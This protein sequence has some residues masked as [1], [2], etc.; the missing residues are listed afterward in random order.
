MVSVYAYIR[1]YD[2]VGS[3]I[4]QKNSDFGKKL[5]EQSD[6]TGNFSFEK[7]MKDSNRI[8]VLLVG[9]EHSRTDTIMIASYDRDDKI[10]NI[11][12]IPRDTYYYREGRTGGSLKINAIYGQEG[13]E[14]L[15]S[16]V[17]EIAGIPIHKHVLIGYEG[18]VKGVDAL[19][20][21]EV[22]IQEG[23]L[24]YEDPYQDL[25]IHIP[26][27]RQLLNGENSLKALRCR[28]SYAGGS[29]L[30]RIAF[31]QQWVKAVVGKL[32]S[33]KLPAFLTEVYSYVE[34]DFSLSEL[35]TLATDAPGFSMT[36]FYNQTLPNYHEWIGGVS[37]VHPDQEKI[38][39]M[40]YQM[41]GI[42]DNST[43]AGSQEDD[44]EDEV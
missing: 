2:P 6:G 5:D 15:I 9:L 33:F 18:L 28:H 38:I 41:Y 17:E 19:G 10:A 30:E 31:Q 14:S 4:N 16:A 1:I 23:G 24:H 22:D 11:V 25:Y 44:A 7:V 37:F 21:V 13:L 26:G 34:T 40:V 42:I 29:D 3:A 12:S 35:L 20:G 43:K 39:E 36:N 27:G 8:N 32:I